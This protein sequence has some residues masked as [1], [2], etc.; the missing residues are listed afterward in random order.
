M[1][2]LVVVLRIEIGTQYSKYEPSASLSRNGFE[3]G[4]QS[5]AVLKY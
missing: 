5:E 3:D 4:F 2:S 1:V